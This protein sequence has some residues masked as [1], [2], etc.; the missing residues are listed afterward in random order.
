[1]RSRLTHL[2]QE[3]PKRLKHFSR[4]EHC[5]QPGGMVGV[6]LQERPRIVRVILQDNAI[7]RIVVPL[8]TH[9][10]IGVSF[11]YR[12]EWQGSSC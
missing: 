2:Q 7:E 10:K 1:M 3:V 12:V 5:A 6:G 4:G 11:H 9:T 8:R